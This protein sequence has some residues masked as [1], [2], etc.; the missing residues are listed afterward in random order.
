MGIRGAAPF[1]WR[2][3]RGGV[4]EDQLV[5]DADEQTAIEMIIGLRSVP[6]TFGEIADE[7]NFLGHLTRRRGLWT[8]ATV[9][10]VYVSELRRYDRMDD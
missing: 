6:K 2:I 9:R 8:A 3:H 4:T 5:H 7:L 1:G 10:N